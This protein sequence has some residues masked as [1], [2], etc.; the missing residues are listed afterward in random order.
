M[1]IGFIV[2]H[3]SYG[4][5]GSFER[6]HLICMHLNRL[7]VKTT[8]LTPYEEDVRRITDIDMQLIP[9][10]MAMMGLSSFGYNLIRKFSSHQPT[11]RVLLSNRFLMKM[12][13]NIR[14]GIY[15]VLKDKR[16]D[17]LNAVQPIAALACGRI[18]KEFN[19]PLVTDLHN[20]WPEESVV[21][22]LI[23]RGDDKFDLLHNYEQTIIDSS[24]AITVVS[25]FMKSYIIRNYS[26]KQKSIIVVPPSGSVI[27]FSNENK[28]MSNVV[29]A[30]L[31]SRREHV[32]LYAHSIPF[33]KQDASFFIS[34]HGEAVNK[35]KKITN[36]RSYPKVNYFWFRNRNDVVEFLKKSK[37]G[38]LTSRNDIT[39]QIGPPLK[40]FEY[41]SCGLPVVANDIGGWT[42][43]IER[44][45]IGLLA[46]DN[47]K[48]FADS[49]DKILSDDSLW[50]KMNSNA[51]R[52]IKTKN[53]WQEIAQRI[54]IP[55]YTTL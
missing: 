39:R 1:N 28:R 40:L 24:D 23:E 31:V 30:G 55:L 16:F 8:V 20:I 2:S 18:A 47:P 35:I 14:S 10:A 26:V 43:M 17:I 51:L 45:Q 33:V 44:D 3:L 9:N 13:N 38:I 11:S 46:D 22:G 53:N 29:Y 5:P 21:D 4:S 34:N 54:L 27:D 52:I 12:I 36:I 19:I 25:D 50:H 49:V 37:I 6:S 42:E 48:Y 15:K 41:M 32:D 7:G